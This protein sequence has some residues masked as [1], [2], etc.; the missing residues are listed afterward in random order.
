MVTVAVVPAGKDDPL[1]PR[2]RCC[3]ATAANDNSA[4]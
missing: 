3:P 1:K 2:L 4:C